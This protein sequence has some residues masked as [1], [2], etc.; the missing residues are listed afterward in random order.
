MN[1]SNLDTGRFAEQS[2]PPAALGQQGE[3]QATPRTFI[4][5]QYN[6]VLRIISKTLK[7]PLGAT[8]P[9]AFRCRRPVLWQP[10]TPAG[11]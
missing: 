6:V 5:G 2:K 11:G 10:L 3:R 7:N 9:L 8:L 1:E 4:K